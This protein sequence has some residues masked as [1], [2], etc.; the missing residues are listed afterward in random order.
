MGDR[1]YD[2]DP[3]FEDVDAKWI[4]DGPNSGGIRFWVLW[5]D[6]MFY[7]EHEGV[8]SSISK[9][10]TPRAFAEKYEGDGDVRYRRILDDLRERGHV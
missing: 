5:R 2:G 3:L 6:H 1:D 9:G 7:G 4:V 10:I 8:S